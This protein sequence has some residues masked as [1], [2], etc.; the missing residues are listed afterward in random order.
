VLGRL[1]CLTDAQLGQPWS[2]RGKPMDIR[3]SLYHALE[4]EQRAVIAAPRAPTE[5]A[6]ILSLAQSAFGDL[7]GLVAGLDDALLDRAPAQ[8][9][10]SVRD[11]LEHAIGVER[12]YRASTR[13]AVTRTAAEP[14][15]MP[16]ER[17]PAPDPAHPTGSILDILE[18]FAEL[19]AET[20]AALAEL[21]DA[22]LARPTVW[23]GVEVDI[24]HRLHRFA[25]HVAEHTI[26]CTKAVVALGATGGDARAICRRIGATRGLHERR[27]DPAR[28]RALD[29]ALEEKVRVAAA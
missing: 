13:Y 21:A 18:R 23:A 16:A 22:D 8:G 9:E 15:L 4:E 10:W 25:S 12:S 14:I 1:A 29:L 20:D 19:R 11:T 27:T 6:R 17:R 5:A 3:Y 7:R 26:Q 24:R 2:F 28:L